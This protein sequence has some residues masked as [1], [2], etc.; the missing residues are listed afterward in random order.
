M[1]ALT[2]VGQSH[3]LTVMV[4]VLSGSMVKVGSL[5]SQFTPVRFV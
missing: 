4:F 1:L 5:I 2:P 3:R